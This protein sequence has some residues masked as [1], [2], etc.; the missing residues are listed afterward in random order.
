MEL[1]DYLRILRPQWWVILL[2]IL[3]GVA[4]AYGWSLLQPKVFQADVTGIVQLTSGG[5]AGDEIVA[6]NLALSKVISYIEYGTSR[7]VAERTIAE[8]GLDT[9]PEALVGKIGVVNPDKTPIIKVTAVSS[10]PE[11]AR[12]LAS[13]WL[14]SMVQQIKSVESTTREVSTEIDG[15]TVVTTET[16]E[17]LLTLV[18]ID[19]A[20]LPTS[21][22]SPNVR[23]A[24][25]LGALIGLALGIAYAVIR[26]TFDRRIRSAGKVE[27]ETGVPVVGTIPV[28]RGFTDDN[29]LIPIASDGND[30]RDKRAAEGHSTA[31]ALREL[32]TNLQFMDVDNPPRVI[33]LTSPVPGDG[34]ST[35][36][37]NLAITVALSGQRVVLIDGD[38]RRPMVSKVFHLPDGGGLTDVLSSRANITDVLH[39][40]SGAKTLQ[41]LTAGKIPPNP[42]EILGSD[43]MNQL[44]QWFAEHALVIIDA[45]PLLAVT[46]AA[47]LA[48]RADGAFVV[49]GVGKT[50]YEMLNKALTILTRSNSRVMGVIL[51]RVP[52]RGADSEYYGY[53]GYYHQQ[54]RD[55]E[56][57]A[58]T[59]S[60]GSKDRKNAA[61]AGSPFGYRRSASEQTQEPDRPNSD[62]RALLGQYESEQPVASE[63][64]AESRRAHRDQ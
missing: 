21:P 51:N 27:S 41:I 29:R 42:S 12:D 8:L 60:R 35:I 32:R 33:V 46:D 63:Q 53:R 4:L 3:L 26:H 58:P 45:P 18:P 43:R 28:N 9:S 57:A 16:V 52:R 31:E 14:T 37:A 19:S 62:F 17:P 44:V 56:R 1:Q 2:S 25:G 5:G 48:N 11:G 6:Q 36:A 22:S 40:W 38:L 10:T 50:T 23:L 47:I 49:T 7:A 13:T 30:G 61:P 55:D 24:L 59:A 34:K 20:I 54:E 64:S 39:T 15:K